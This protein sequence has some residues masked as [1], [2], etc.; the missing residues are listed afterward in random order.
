[1]KGRVDKDGNQLRLMNQNR[2]DVY[3]FISKEIEITF[4]L[5]ASN[6]SCPD[7]HVPRGGHAFPS[8]GS[9]LEGNDKNSIQGLYS[10]TTISR[11]EKYSEM[12]IKNKI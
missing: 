10:D 6:D 1:M 5:I 2:A 3:A 8:L 4:Y 11:V 7:R 9:S 12:I